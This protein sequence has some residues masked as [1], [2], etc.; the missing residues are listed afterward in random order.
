MEHPQA[1]PGVGARA[2]SFLLENDVREGNAPDAADDRM[3]DQF[4]VRREGDAGAFE[5]V[6]AEH[7]LGMGARA[8]GARGG[9]DPLDL[10]VSPPA[11]SRERD[12]QQKRS[13]DGDD[14]H[15][16]FLKWPAN[17]FGGFKDRSGT[18][19]EAIGNWRRNGP[20]GLERRFRLA[21]TTK[22]SPARRS[23]RGEG[24]ALDP[25]P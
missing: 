20:N 13:D 11:N 5:S 12:D 23:G 16:V 19:A 10:A 18:G 22:K 14:G 1:P 24:P 17:G 7:A 15:A 9:E 8:G 2:G 4:V 6:E 3:E 25:Q 21:G